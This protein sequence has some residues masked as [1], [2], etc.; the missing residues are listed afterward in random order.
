MASQPMQASL[1]T[2]VMGVVPSH[3]DI[4]S[5]SR[6]YHGDT[7]IRQI[8]ND[9]LCR[10]HY[11]NAVTLDGLV[12]T[13]E[14]AEK[15]FNVIKFHP[16]SRNFEYQFEIV[17]WSKS[18]EDCLHNDRGRRKLNSRTSI[19]NIPFEEPSKELLEKFDISEKQCI[20]KLVV[21][22]PEHKAW[23]GENDLGDADRLY[24][25][26]WCLGGTWGNCW[27]NSGTVSPGT[28][29]TSFKE[30]DDL[31]ERIC[32]TLNFLQYKKLYN[33]TVSV[34]DYS[35]GDYYGGSVSYAKFVCDLKKLHEMLREMQ[36]I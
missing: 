35:E 8:A 19:E 18:I 13:N 24:S 26:S 33:N 23:A 16:E 27:G 3:A 9:T 25:D 34:E 30:F 4:D 5:L 28:P 6:N 14:V 36:L 17:W 32:P 15:I 29:L 31:M 21:R 22:K 20:R 11:H 10:L 2:E 1:T 12:T 7:L